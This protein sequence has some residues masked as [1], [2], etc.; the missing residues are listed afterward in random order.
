MPTY[1]YQCGVC[2]HRFDAVQSIH[3][4]SLRECPECTGT[5]RKVFGAVGVTFK[6]SG[7][8]R[9]DSRASTSS[10]SKPTTS[11]PSSTSAAAS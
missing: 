8:Y 4:E 6:G 7:F 5:L 11:P 9:T 1:T 10:P 2:A 3:D